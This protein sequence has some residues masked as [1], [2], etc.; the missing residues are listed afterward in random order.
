MQTYTDAEL[1]AMLADGKSE[2]LEL[3]AVWK[4]DEKRS[5]RKVVCA[6]ANDYGEHEKP[7]VL[8]VGL[9]DDGTPSGLE[10]D[11]ELLRRLTDIKLDGRILPIPCLTV[12]KRHL[13]G[14]DVAVMIVRPSE[15]PPVRYDGRIYIRVGSSCIAASVQD[16]KILCEKR[17]EHDLPYDIQTVRRAS[18]DDLNKKRFEE[19]VRR[20]IAPDVLDELDRTYE[21]NLAVCNMVNSPELPIPTV[22]GVLALS[23]NPMKWIGGAIV[24]FLRLEGTDLT[25]PITD[26]RRFVG[27]VSELVCNVDA[28]LD[29]HNHKKVD[30]VSEKLTKENVHYPLLAIKEIFRNAIMHRQYDGTNSPILIYWFDD[31]IEIIS[32]GGPF[33]KVNSRNFG[34][35]GVVD[36]RNLHLSDAMC[37]L[38]LVNRFGTGIQLAQKAMKENGN[39]PIE[40]DIQPESVRCVLR[41][42]LEQTSERDGK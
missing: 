42:C 25:A 39:P 36:Y 32:A 13:R 23:E 6:F 17:L 30:N 34:Q 28:R 22:L 18:V 8:I 15:A 14:A 41:K 33:G 12:E 24:Q 9:D 5:G 27:S 16:E 20:A 37:V 2:L 4:Q 10:I 7:G 31:R 19:Y 40:F 11:D 29:V 35:S 21:Q 38:G 26:E 3:K 1:E